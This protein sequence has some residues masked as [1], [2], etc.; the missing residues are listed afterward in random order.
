MYVSEKIKPILDKIQK[1]L[2]EGM[3]SGKMWSRPW[4]KGGEED[5]SSPVNASSGRVYAGA[6]RLSLWFESVGRGWQD[7]RFVT[8]NQCGKMGG[9]IKKGEKGVQILY[10]EPWVRLATPHEG[11]LWYRL[12]EWRDVELDEETKESLDPKTIFIMRSATVYNVSQTTLEL[13][14]KQS[15]PPLEGA[16]NEKAEQLIERLSESI[17]VRYGEGEALYR[18]GSLPD[19]DCGIEMPPRESFSDQ[20]D[21][22]RTIFHEYSHAADHSIRK[23]DFDEDRSGSGKKAVRELVA[24]IGTFVACS[25]TGVPFVPRHEN[26]IPGWCD[27]LARLPEKI[28]RAFVMFSFTGGEKASQWIS[29]GGCAPAPILFAGDL[30]DADSDVDFFP[31]EEFGAVSESTPKDKKMAAAI[32]F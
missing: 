10:N 11:K 2:L 32:P 4:N 17:P 6:N 16:R 5:C 24:E 13:E 26:S 29:A 31:E 21:F 14:T 30:D 19:S 8:R 12:P 15:P 22:Y 1:N 18:H 3:K 20:N 27:D 23:I 7:N 9:E 25:N 28:R